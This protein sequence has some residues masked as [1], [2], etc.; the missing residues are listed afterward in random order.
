M[1]GDTSTG[2]I[3]PTKLAGYYEGEDGQL[4]QYRGPKEE[5]FLL[6][7]SQNY[8]H[9]FGVNAARSAGM[10]SGEQTNLR[11]ASEGV[12]AGQQDLSAAAQGRVNP[13]AAQIAG[14]AATG[15]QQGN[16]AGRLQS[17]ADRPEGPSAAQAQLQAGTN[18][19]LASNLALARSGG[20]F[21]ESAGSLGQAGR[22]AATAI[23]NQGTSA[24]QLRAQE[25]QA[26]RAQRLQALGMSGDV[27]G[28]QRSGT[29]A[30]GTQELQAQQQRDA[31]ALGYAAEARANR[32]AASDMS[33]RAE[34]AR[35]AGMG[36]GLEAERAALEGRQ[37]YE[38]TKED[39]YK[40]ELGDVQATRAADRA[41]DKDWA[42][43]ASGAIEAIGGVF[44]LSDVR[45]KTNIVPTGKA[46]RDFETYQG[47]DKDLAWTPRTK[48][49]IT[50]AQA[51]DRARDQKQE[52]AAAFANRLRAFG[53]GAEHSDLAARSTAFGG[54][55]SNPGMGGNTRGGSPYMTARFMSDEDQK[56]D[57]S[58]Y[59]GVG[60]YDYNYKD[61]DR[62][63][64]GRFRGP[65]A[66]ELEDIP[67]VVH[68]TPEGKMVD[69][70]RLAMANAS[71][72]GELRREM[73]LLR[74]GR[75]R[76][77]STS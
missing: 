34:E 6:G 11:T 18:Q 39:L 70:G 19:A 65:M 53:G 20:G 1:V 66:Q 45:A 23:A 24:A 12:A 50:A 77:A 76:S 26:D 14:S 48:Q 36:L 44:G 67:G 42:D 72:I 63:G 38:Q 37:G 73:E 55:G 57:V 75:G 43:T 62:H 49:G 61:P 28:A 58:E 46:M 52:R 21:G 13:A 7:G 68:D 22:N 74:R 25:T 17:F 60:K 31:A 40:A 69:S 33:A 9:D 3:H 47:T 51:N 59:V 71:E 29:Q 10:A 27:L 15:A 2:A 5:N 4:K 35:R 41:R 32:G 8:A 16:L 64:H 56:E 30:E 54:M